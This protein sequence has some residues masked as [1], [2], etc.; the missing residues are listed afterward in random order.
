MGNVK[1]ITEKVDNCFVT[2]YDPIEIGEKIRIILS[3]GL[4][5]NGRIFMKSYGL[6]KI[7]KKVKIAYETTLKI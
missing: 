6:D 1:S 2:S 7:A 4:R 5:T 3:S